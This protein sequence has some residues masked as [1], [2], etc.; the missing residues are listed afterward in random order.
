MVHSPSH[1]KI[2]QLYLMPLPENGYALCPLSVL[3][4]FSILK[5]ESKDATTMNNVVLTKCLP[6]QIRF[7]NPN[8][9]VNTGSSRKLP[10][11]S[12]NRSGLKESGSGYLTRSR[13]I[14]LQV[15]EYTA[16]GLGRSSYRTMHSLSQ[17]YLIIPNGYQRRRRG[18]INTK[19]TNPWG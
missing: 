8:A 15:V 3:L 10:S 1:F 16:T 18:K 6:G 19:T 17:E 2:R 13:K 9:V 14:A 4:P 11:E 7:P 5:T 12:R